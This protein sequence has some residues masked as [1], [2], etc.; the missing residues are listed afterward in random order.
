MSSAVPVV[1]APIPGLER[2]ALATS[3]FAA[4]GV[5]AFLVGSGLSTAAGI[6]TGERIVDDLIS[7]I[8]R[9]RGVAESDYVDDPRAWWL[10][11]TGR[12]VRYDELLEEVAPTDAAR[13]ALLR[14]YFESRDDG[15]PVEPTSAHIALAQLCREGFVRVILTT[16]FDTLLERAL[17]ACEVSAQV[18]SSEDAIRGRIPL[19]HSPATVIKLHGDYRSLGLRNTPLELGSYGLEQRALL[20]QVFEEFGLVA[21]G[22]SGEWD[23]ALAGEIEG[24]VSRRYPTYWVSYHDDLTTRARQIINNR[25]ASH[26]ISDGADDFLPDLATRIDRLAERTRRRAIP[27]FRRSYQNPPID[28][29][30]NGWSAIPWLVLRTVATPG[31]VD[32]D[33]TGLIGPEIRDQILAGLRAAPFWGQLTA[34]NA[35]EPLDASAPVRMPD[36]TIDSTGSDAAPT[37]T[38]LSDWEVVPGVQSMNRAVYRLGND[39]RVGASAVAEIQLPFSRHENVLFILDIGVSIQ[40][41]LPLFEVAQVLRDG[42][43]LVSSTLPDAVAD[44]LPAHLEVSRCD[45]HFTASRSDGRAGTRDN[46]IDDRIDLRPFQSGATGSHSNETSQLG[47]GADITQRLTRPDASELIAEGFNYTALLL[48]FLDPRAAITQIRAALGFPAKLP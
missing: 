47:F 12:D 17:D 37:P 3:M 33:G 10:L 14:R 43:V 9:Q 4:P 24:T 15:Q 18:L 39:G 29:V 23:R 36:G 40:R 22:W 27:A 45:V 35:S 25:R 31:S 32:A 13:Q 16:N 46:A 7:N 38:G 8:A 44:I 48:G 5:Y 19:V 2:D 11:E 21:V 1:Q 42:L 6:L 20:R 30:R 26:V 41:P 34:W 28:G